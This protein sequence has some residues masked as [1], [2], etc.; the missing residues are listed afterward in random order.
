MAD[1]DEIKGLFSDTQKTVEALRSDVESLKG[2]SDDF[3][4]RDRLAKIEADLA[5]KFEAEQKAAMER[6][7]ALETAANRPGGAGKGGEPDA[8]AKAFGDYLRKG[9]EA[10]ELKA[11]S[12]QIN[13]DGGYMVSDGMEAGIRARLRRTSPS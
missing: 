2:K 5:A 4:D 6:L 12:T 9:V 7:D 8:K 11:M 1:L 3:V 10:E 13:A